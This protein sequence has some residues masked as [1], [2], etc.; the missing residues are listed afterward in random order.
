MHLAS[1]L[2]WLDD[3]PTKLCRQFQDILQDCFHSSFVMPLDARGP[4]IF[5]DRA[6]RTITLEPCREIFA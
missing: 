4:V 5:C 1:F 2:I 3:T 6:R